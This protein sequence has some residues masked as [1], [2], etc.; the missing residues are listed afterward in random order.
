M[1]VSAAE[2]DLDI[3]FLKGER[4]RLLKLPPNPKWISIKTDQY[5]RVI[6]HLQDLRREAQMTGL[7]GKRIED[8]ERPS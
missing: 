3:V 6:K 8:P 1:I 4:D 7:G 2:L 5:E